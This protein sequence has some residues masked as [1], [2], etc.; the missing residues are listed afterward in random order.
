[1]R[2]VPLRSFHFLLFLASGRRKEKKIKKKKK[3]KKKK[4]FLRKKFYPFPKK[5]PFS[6]PFNPFSTFFSVL[7]PWTPET[8][9]NYWDRSRSRS[10]SESTRQ[11]TPPT[12]NGHAP[13][14]SESRK[15][16]NESAC[17]SSQSPDPVSF[18][19][20]GQIQAAHSTPCCAF[21][22]ILLSF[23]LAIRNPPR[24]RTLN[25]FPIVGAGL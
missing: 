20:L 11:I 1:M 10:L 17:Q 9:Q 4:L 7:K 23:S 16:L 13:P 12:K 6:S 25:G 14:T 21:P 18:P 2:T 3:R 22:S 8:K 5:N 15:V 24:V 19:V